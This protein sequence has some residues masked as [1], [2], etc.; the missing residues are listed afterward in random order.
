MSNGTIGGSVIW[1]DYYYIFLNFSFFLSCVIVSM[2]LWRDL[3]L[4]QLGKFFFFLLFSHLWLVWPTDNRLL[5]SRSL[6]SG[7]WVFDNLR[8]IRSIVSGF[9]SWEILVLCSFANPWSALFEFHWLLYQGISAGGIS[10][11]TFYRSP[12]WAHH[13]VLQR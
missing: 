9:L 11:S 8:F 7:V 3:F 6:F 5:D 2:P 1:T 10:T 13:K 12:L 4:N